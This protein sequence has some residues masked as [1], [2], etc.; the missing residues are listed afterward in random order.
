[1]ALRTKLL[2]RI[3]WTPLFDVRAWVNDFDQ[4]LRLMWDQYLDELG[5]QTSNKQVSNK[6]L[7]ILTSRPRAIF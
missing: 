4:S 6:A 2:R 1:L 7:H 3:V 5:S